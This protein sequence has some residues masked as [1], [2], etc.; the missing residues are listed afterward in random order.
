VALAEPA[1]ITDLVTRP[2]PFSPRLV[3][4]L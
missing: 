4:A 3:P 2:V 1:K